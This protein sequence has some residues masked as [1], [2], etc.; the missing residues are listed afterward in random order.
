MI[1]R[2]LRKLRSSSAQARA[3]ASRTST[4]AV[5]PTPAGAR[6]LDDPVAVPDTMPEPWRASLVRAFEQLP[7]ADDL[8]RPTNFWQPG[9]V[10]LMNDLSTRGIETFKSWPSSAFFFYPRYSPVFTYAQV[11][12]VMPT[13]REAAPKVG[14][15]WFHNRLIGAVDANRDLD[16]ATAMFDSATVPLDVPRHGESNVG[17]P[18]QRYRPFGA[19]GPG[20]GKPYLNYLLIMSAVS[21]HIDRPLRSVLE[22]GAGFGVLGEILLQSDPTIQYVDLDIPPL[23]VIAHYYLSSVFPQHVFRSNLDLAA[24]D[25]FEL[26]DGQPCACLSAWHL[27][28]LSG[29]TDL[30]VNAFSFQ[31]MEPEVVENYAT[32]IARLGARFVVSLNSRAGKPLAEHSAIGVRRQVTSQ[33]I[34]DSF[35]ALGYDTVARV[36]RPIAPPQAE[37]LILRRKA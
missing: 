36:G 17:A 15:D 21:R 20:Y 18:P 26:G 12:Q 11:D 35:A 19:D 14:K 4:N 31:E 25:T 16:V 13:L 5:P 6:Q 30:F 23:S 28:Q 8:Y 10:A 32:G 37:L 24:G 27:P 33:F 1:R 7:N 29:S 34:H 3:T 9:V 2:A 22:L